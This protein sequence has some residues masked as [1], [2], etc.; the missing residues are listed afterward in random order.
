VQFLAESLL[1]VG[2]GGL[3]GTLLGAAVTAGYARVRV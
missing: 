3:A 1:L 2:L